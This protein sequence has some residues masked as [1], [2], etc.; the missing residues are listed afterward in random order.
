[1]YIYKVNKYKEARNWNI[2]FKKM[3]VLLKKSKEFEEII[4]KI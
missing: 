4:I 2:V 3:K 1:M